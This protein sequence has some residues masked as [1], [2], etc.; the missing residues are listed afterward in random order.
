MAIHLTWFPRWVLI[1]LD[2]EKFSKNRFLKNRWFHL[3]HCGVEGSPEWNSK[4]AVSKL[5]F[6]RALCIF[7]FFDLTSRSRDIVDSKIGD[8]TFALTQYYQT[9]VIFAIHWSTTSSLGEDWVPRQT[10]RT[11]ESSWRLISTTAANQRGGKQGREAGEFY[12]EMLRSFWCRLTYE[13]VP[14]VMWFHSWPTVRPSGALVLRKIGT[15][16]SQCSV[17]IGEEWLTDVKMTRY[18]GLLW[19]RCWRGLTKSCSQSCKR[20]LYSVISYLILWWRGRDPHMYI[21]QS[22]WR[23]MRR[24][25]TYLRGE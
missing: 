25:I 23:R 4:I 24:S 13:A 22:L 20:T 9:S 17:G 11:W 7:Y 8:K 14:N 1:I 2:S 18:R 15:C 21:V 3:H 5:R 12:L 16:Y 6:R 19:K 10:P